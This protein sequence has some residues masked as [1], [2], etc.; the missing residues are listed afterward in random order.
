MYPR[1]G[2]ENCGGKFLRGGRFSVSATCGGDRPSLTLGLDGHWDAEE[3]GFYLGG[4]G[5]QMREIWR[6]EIFGMP[7][8]WRPLAEKRTL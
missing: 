1:F 6:F 8:L 2:R 5:P 4:I 3:N 7:R